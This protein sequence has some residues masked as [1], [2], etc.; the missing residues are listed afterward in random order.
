MKN[1]KHE[2]APHSLT[3]QRLMEMYGLLFER[4]GPQHWW[5]GEMETEIMLGAVLAQNT[6]WKNVERAILN[7]KRKGLISVEAL[8]AC[9]VSVLAE[10]V[11]PAGYYNLKA[12]RVK[13]LIRMIRQEFDGDLNRMFHEDPQSLRE[14]LLFVNGIGRE[15]ADS[16]LLYAAG[17]P[18]FV[19]DGYTHRILLRHGMVDEQCTYEELQSLFMDGLPESAALFNEFHAL[20]VKTGKDLCRKIPRCETCPLQLWGPTSPRASLPG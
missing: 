8:E 18:V 4:F 7:L 6:S 5:P 17:M 14:R 3:G 12:R 16:I 11:R 10:E 15:T 20:I 1:P 19:V 9:D 13:N 2:T